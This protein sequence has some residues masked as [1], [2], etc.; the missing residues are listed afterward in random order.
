MVFG[1]IKLFKLFCLFFIVVNFYCIIKLF[2]G[3]YA[4]P[5][6][7]ENTRLYQFTTMND[8]TTVS[9]D[10]YFHRISNDVRVFSGPTIVSQNAEY[11]YKEQTTT[12]HL[13][14]KAMV[15]KKLMESSIVTISKK[16][17]VL[18]RANGTLNVLTK[19]DIK[20]FNI[21]PDCD[22][23]ND[24]RILEQMSLTYHLSNKLGNA[25]PKTINLYSGFA[26]DPNVIAD[27]G[28]T[29]FKDCPL[30]CKVEWNRQSSHLEAADAIMLMTSTGKLVLP[31]HNRSPDQIWVFYNLEPAWVANQ[32]KHRLSGPIINWTMT[33]YQHSTISIPY[34]KYIKFSDSEKYPF[35][36][37]QIQEHKQRD[38]YKVNDE[39]MTKDRQA[40]VFMSNCFSRNNRLGYIHDLQ[41]YINVDVYGQCGDLSCSKL[42]ENECSELLEKHYK[43]YLA[44]EN[45]NCQ[46]Y[47]TE[48][49]FENALRNHVIPVVMGGRR[50]NYVQM[51]PPNSF[52][53]V[54]DFKNP[55]S[56]AKYL[57]KIDKN[58]E[59]FE[60][61]FD[62][63]QQGMMINT[64][65]WC[66]LCT[67]LHIKQYYPPRH[68]ESIDKWW[69]FG[70]YCE[71]GM[72]AR[73]ELLK[74]I[75]NVTYLKNE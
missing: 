57:I 61:Y 64:L 52:I 15:L 75:K 74:R 31:S 6:Y 60:S 21:W 17:R 58:N 65:S 29:Y 66:R 2:K 70:G 43:F 35:L 67:M 19:E 7:T 54:K 69:R 25:A 47:I 63:H 32:L 42:R 11:Q 8:I 3:D 26:E 40:A 68:Y 16:D 22:K 51:A 20:D 23:P 13:L 1:I 34:G 38:M 9:N 30:S 56:L 71:K 49:F 37:S 28:T 72:F 27:D 59:L 50:D 24:D 36:K 41:R 4:M 46:Q 5:P 12:T 45:S 55:E 73:N 44:F 53:H 14:N 10:D 62:W 18:N 48:K 33:Y 39:R